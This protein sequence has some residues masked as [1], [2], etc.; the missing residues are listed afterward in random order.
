MKLLL[1]VNVVLK[2]Q[3]NLL[4]AFEDLLVLVFE[5]DCTEVIELGH[6]SD[7]L[8]LFFEFDRLEEVRYNLIV[9]F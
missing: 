8:S 3:L 7:E 4:L 2:P 1:D 5:E 9:V 6:Q